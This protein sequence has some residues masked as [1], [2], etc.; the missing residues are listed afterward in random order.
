MKRVL[1]ILVLASIAC[2]MP[3]AII[4]PEVL[5]SPT[6]MPTLTPIPVPTLTVTP[7]KIC[8]IVTASE[9][10][11]LRSGPSA[12]TQALAWLT[13]GEKV[14]ATGKSVGN[15]WPVEYGALAGWVHADFVEACDG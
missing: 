11:H 6:V 13:N 2:A 12:N 8:L 5:A 9:A 1:A 15:W 3:A 7:E 10:L 14:L 4:E